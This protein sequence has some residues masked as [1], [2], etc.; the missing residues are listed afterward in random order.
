VGVQVRTARAEDHARIIAVLDDWWGGRQLSALLPSLF[1]ENFAGTSL[2]AEDDGELVGFLVGF[3][4]ADRADEAYVHFVGVHPG[5][6]GSG[7]GTSLHD[8]F[9]EQVAATGVR[10]IRCV[11]STTNEASVAFHTSIGFVVDGTDDAVP[12]SGTDDQVGHVRLSRPVPVHPQRFAP[13]LD[14]RP[15][16]PPYPTTAEDTWPIPPDTRLS[17]HV[18]ELTVSDVERDAFELFAA[19]DSDAVWAHVRGRPDDAEAMAHLIRTKLTDPTWCPWTVR[20]LR[21]VGGLPAGSVVG[22][23]SYLE[24]STGD[25]RGEIGSTSYAPAVWGGV[26]NPECKLLLLGY[27]FDLLGW[28]RVQ[29]KTDTRNHRSQQAIA[30]LGARYEGTQRRYQ[31]RADGSVRDSPVF[32]VTREDWPAVRDG[33]RGRVS[34]ATTRD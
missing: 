34:A 12:A 9:A 5:R 15:G 2:V 28:G 26:V 8:R 31:R 32:S 18:V 27:A 24:V 13:R 1:L 19:L 20:L 23:T 6:R 3:V 14:P 4:S 21:P 33:L 30:R 22:T 10:T 7:L 11:T 29:L 17:G 25:A 16:D